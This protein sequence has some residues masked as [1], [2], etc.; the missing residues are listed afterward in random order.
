MPGCPAR[1]LTDD[2]AAV[3]PKA[4]PCPGP[5][6]SSPSSV[7]PGYVSQRCTRQSAFVAAR[8]ILSGRLGRR[9]SVITTRFTNNQSKRSRQNTPIPETPATV[10]H[11]VSGGVSPLLNGPGVS[12]GSAPG[13]HAV[14][15]KGVR[16]SLVRWR[17]P[18]SKMTTAPAF[19][20]GRRRSRAGFE[21]HR[22][23]PKAR[24]CPVAGPSVNPPSSECWGYA[25]NRRVQ[26]N[27]VV[28]RGDILK[29]CERLSIRSYYVINTHHCAITEVNAFTTRPWGCCSADRPPRG[30]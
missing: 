30:S 8:R 21:R 5:P 12:G 19:V 25:T 11:R 26:M 2:L 3:R 13:S 9:R 16:G 15:C 7:G 1:L 20:L 17:S 23:K 4:R 22:I 14:V 27:A 29:P 28:Q 18:F 24:R 6:V 10:Q